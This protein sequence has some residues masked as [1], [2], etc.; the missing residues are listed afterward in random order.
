M[1][2]NNLFSRPSEEVAF[3]LVGRTLERKWGKGYIQGLII[4]TGAYEEGNE[5]PSRAG[6]KYAP[7]TIFLM[8]FRGSSLLNIS[9][10][11]EGY[12]SCV[13]IRQVQF[14]DRE[15]TG[16]GAITKF[17]SLSDLDGEILGEQLRITG[18]SANPS[19]VRGMLG[20]SKNCL[21]YFTFK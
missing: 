21:G 14:E 11:R 13:E 7:G 18:T 12:P 20:D 5:T 17:L 9:T 2:E 16:S 6:M 4:E 8:P 10:D 3:R 15:V 1:S 19:V